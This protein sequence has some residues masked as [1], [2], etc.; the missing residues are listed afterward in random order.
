VTTI[1]ERPAAGRGRVYRLVPFGPGAPAPARELAG[2]H[3]ALLP[4]SP[5]ALL[6]RPFMER[7]Y[8]RALPAEGLL[9]GAVAY[10]DDLPAGFAVATADSSG[11]MRT[12]VRR[13]WPRLA[14]VLGAS[15]IL[16]PACVAPMWQ[17]LRVM[18]QRRP[19]AP[20][21]R[22]GEILSMGI[23]PAY[24]TPTFMRESRLRIST[25]LVD[26]VVARLAEAGV[27]TIRAIVAG[28]NTQAKLLYCGLGWT[29]NRTDVPEW[30]TPTAEFVWRA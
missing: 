7:F 24:R 30:T 13:R 9:V 8:Y 23:L 27:R 11:F 4:Q 10:V 2:L 18:R 22:T 17:A 25:D 19:V 29:L 1:L 16:H 14:W 20:A 26:H 5:I 3:A 15:A 21:D 28:D 12:A 6:G